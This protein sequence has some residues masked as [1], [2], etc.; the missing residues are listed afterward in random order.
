MEDVWIHLN[1]SIFQS[2]NSELIQRVSFYDSTFHCLQPLES[3]TA[4]QQVFLALSTMDRANA[5]AVVV[6]GPWAVEQLSGM[7]ARLSKSQVSL[8]ISFTIGMCF[9]CALS[10]LATL[11]VRSCPGFDQNISTDV[12]PWTHF[13]SDL[14]L[15][16]H[17]ALLCIA[18]FFN[19]L[20]SV[21][22]WLGQHIHRLLLIY[23]DLKGS[24][25]GLKA[26][27]AELLNHRREC[28]NIFLDNE[29]S[30]IR[31]IMGGSA[32]TNISSKRFF[33]LAWQHDISSGRDDLQEILLSKRP[34]QWTPSSARCPA[35]SS[36]IHQSCCSDCRITR[37]LWRDWLTLVIQLS[38]V[39]PNTFHLC[40]LFGAVL[41]GLPWITNIDDG[42]TPD[43]LHSL[44]VLKWV[45]ACVRLRRQRVFPGLTNEWQKFQFGRPVVMSIGRAMHWGQDRRKLR[46]IRSMAGG[47]VALSVQDSKS[48]LINISVVP[49]ICQDMSLKIS[50]V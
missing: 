39:I 26:G 11:M 24:S 50:V 36:E 21:R 30:W 25:L 15:I 28:S 35:C 16:L 31:T 48:Q 5:I 7:A 44:N 43:T 41:L 27:L 29:I 18:F 38:I 33:F 4:V 17:V 37:I 9:F 49:W 34:H 1:K 12:V 13:I 14:I 3:V 19:Q 20:L 45:A 32:P 42:R 22:F 8:C 47:I 10:A 2:K 40:F 23:K 46:A 6:Q